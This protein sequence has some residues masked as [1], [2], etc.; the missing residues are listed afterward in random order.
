MATN[1]KRYDDDLIIRRFSNG[2][3]IKPKDEVLKEIKKAFFPEPSHPEPPG[4]Y[5]YVHDLGIADVLGCWD[6]EYYYCSYGN[7]LELIGT[8]FSNVRDYA[9]IDGGEYVP[10]IFG[11]NKDDVL[12][13]AR[14]YAIF[15]EPAPYP[16]KPKVKPE[17]KIS[18]K[19]T[20]NNIVPIKKD[21]EKC[22]KKG[23]KER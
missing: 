7:F 4:V 3:L 23:E 9:D 2:D 5:F 10:I 13:R 21:S 1:G 20:K 6:K 17:D 15:D 22:D 8:I 18:E 12:K 16:S 14:E 19:E 11:T